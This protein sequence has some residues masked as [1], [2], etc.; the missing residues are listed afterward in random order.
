MVNGYSVGS[1]GKD[2]SYATVEEVH[3]KNCTFQGTEN[4]ARIK[5][6]KVRI[7]SIC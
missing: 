1:L 2:G 3:V 7:D 5:T 6:W 4:G